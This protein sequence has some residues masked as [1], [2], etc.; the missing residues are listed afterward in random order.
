[1]NAMRCNSLIVDFPPGRIHGQTNRERRVTFA[2]KSQ[3]RYIKYPSS[4]EI[5]AL[6]YTEDE[7]KA[8]RRQMLRDAVKCSI[9][10]ADCFSNAPQ[11]LASQD[12]VGLEHLISRD[13]GERYQSLKVA[14]REHAGIVLAE[15]KSQRRQRRNSIEDLAR[16]SGMSSY[17][18]RERSRKV[19]ILVAAV[20]G[21][22]DFWRKLSGVDNLV[23]LYF[24][25]NV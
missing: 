7:I 11:N 8:F 2:N 4:Q 16:V 25:I 19:G 14:R 22:S 10:M 6:W 24:I 20:G 21:K 12:Y 17:W 3:G 13:V 5:R 1:M 9:K 15:Q 18:S 23:K